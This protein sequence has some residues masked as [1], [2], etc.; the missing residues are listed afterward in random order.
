MS[1][2]RR[3]ARQ[4]DLTAIGQVSAGTRLLI[5]G[6]FALNILLSIGVVR[7]QI[8]SIPVR[9]AAAVACLGLLLIAAP[10]V[11]LDTVRRG[12]GILLLILGFAAIGAGVTLL[13]G[14]GWGMIGRQLAEIHF[15]A[16]FGYVLAGSVVRVC[17]VRATVL[18][19]L[20]MVGISV[21][22]A[23]LQLIRVDFAWQT[24]AMLGRFQNEPPIT[25][26]FYTRR[27]R[28]LGISY[29][30]V[31]LGTQA[32]LSFA[33]FYA[34]RLYDR[35]RL[36]LKGFDPWVVV[37]LSIMI[38]VCFVSGNRSPILGAV[39]FIA[40]YLL[41]TA[42]KAFWLAAPFA[43]V[44]VPGLLT[45]L[46]ILAEAG[47]RVASVNDGSALGRA[48]LADYGWRLF[49]ARPI[50]YGYGFDSTQHWSEYWQYML[51][52]ANPEQIRRFAPHNYVIIMLNKYGIGLLLL[53]PLIVPRSR[54]AWAAT[55]PFLAYLLHI[56]FHNDGPLLADFLFWYVVAMFGPALALM[57]TQS[58][59]NNSSINAKLIPRLRFSTWRRG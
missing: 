46:P 36:G 38:A 5:L 24:R 40:I 52:Y 43:V 14:D 4:A 42:P 41:V 28:P 59:T 26:L 57:N 27:E 13:Y 56:L 45:L 11:V 49:A 33:A 23:V 15:Q 31:H 50:G 55:L 32:C 18:A 29:T 8:A 3:T 2:Y 6:L 30:P 16:A 47:I 37:A 10:G 1:Q 12:A 54:A 35:A 53:L 44:G 39:V 48:V 25:Q 7:W 51:Y 17:G 19:F 20:A 9:S 58:G 22:F 21:A 34:W